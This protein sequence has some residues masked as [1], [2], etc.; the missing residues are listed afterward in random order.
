[1]TLRR[2]ASV[3]ATSLVAIVALQVAGCSTMKRVNPFHGRPSPTK[4]EAGQR[5]SLLELND[6][7]KV[8][9]SLRGQDFFLPPAQPQADWP[10]AGGTLEQSVEHVAA[11][12]DLQIAWRK[13]FGAKSARHADVMAPPIMAEGKVF[14]MDGNAGV[15]AHDARTG[16]QVWRV[17][18][19]PKV[20]HDRDREAFGG[21]LA[22][23]DGKL[24]VSSG[25]RLVAELDAAN[26]HV[27]WLTRT[28]APV[29]DAPTVA[30]GRVYVV[31][32]DDELLTFNS[33]TG[34]PDWT[35]QA[36]TEPARMLMASS[37][38]VSNGTLVT[39][40]ASGELVALR[41][42]NG[43]ELWNAPL[44]HT[45]RT[46]AL[47][48]IRDIAGRPVIYKG[49]V[50]AV[51]HADVMAATNLRTGEVRWTIPLS[52]FTSPWPAGDVVF[53]V[54]TAG[55][56]ICASR[57][58]GQL[59]WLTDLNAPPP[60][61]KGKKP[62]K[63]P[64]TVW[65]GPILASDRLILASDR[66]ELVALNPKTGALE[67]RLKISDDTLLSPIAAGGMIYLATQKADLIAI[68]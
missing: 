28:D 66:G 5:I 27:E 12:P 11:A 55:N 62:A 47:S 18:L 57:D 53:A 59:Y 56:V 19:R 48:E 61:K 25:Y 60:P 41:E 38:A 13:N 35:Y 22:Y 68:R 21:G 9:D 4:T 65:S 63:R 33:G 17:D 2:N 32:V 6:Q 64:H 37:P 3:I 58:S 50:F 43:T 7:L 14:V 31:D 44:S 40:F 34:V 36:L 15:S 49:D 26:G 24:Y 67:K 52:G 54:D 30:D 23:A 29:H 16:G 1:M 46:N 20:K 8:S 39:S 42:D 45:T 10:V 51:S